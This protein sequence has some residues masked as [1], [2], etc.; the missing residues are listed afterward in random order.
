M[1]DKQQIFA[2]EYLVDCN[3]TRA[4][5]VAYPNIKNDNTAAA[6]S[7]RLLRNDKVKTYIDEQLKKMNDAKIADATE[8][9]Q[10]LT[11][12]MRG[13][14][15]SEVLAVVGDGDGFSSVEH[16]MKNPDEKERL[17]AAELLSKRYG[18]LKMTIEDS[19]AQERAEKLDNIAGIL[20]QMTPP[21]DGD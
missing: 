1:T 14:S 12:V 3:A 2:N 20:A 13:Q 4:Y 19:S 9:M 8:V 15:E 16:V 11:S 21:K 18:L 10:Y 6:C 7:A 17:K 5:K